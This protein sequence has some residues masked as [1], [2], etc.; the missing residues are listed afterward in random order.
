MAHWLH[1][2]LAMLRFEVSNQRLFLP[3]FLIVQ[4]MLGAGMAVMY[5]FFL[6]DDMPPQAMT[7]VAT[8]IPALALVPLGFLA[9]PVVV[10]QLRQ[11]GCYDFV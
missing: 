11:K 5:G 3:V 7:Y 1:G 10:G 8:G 2:Y 9:V 6:G 4:V